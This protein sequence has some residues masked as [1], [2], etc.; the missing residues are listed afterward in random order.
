M[1]IWKGF[2]SWVHLPNKEVSICY[3]SKIMAKVKVFFFVIDRITDIGG[4]AA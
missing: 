3:G 2:T 4:N 1:V